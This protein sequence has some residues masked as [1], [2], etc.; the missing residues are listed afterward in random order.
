MDNLIL[1]KIRK[2]AKKVE[3]RRCSMC[4]KFADSKFYDLKSYSREWGEG[5]EIIVCEKCG[6]KE[7]FGAVPKTSRK[8]QR[9]LEEGLI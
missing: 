8:Y 6:L 1:R 3:P 5:N 7:E 2:R 9:A 4:G